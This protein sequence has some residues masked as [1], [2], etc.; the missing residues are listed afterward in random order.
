MK[1]LKALGYYALFILYY[2]ICFSIITLTFYNPNGDSSIGGISVFLMLMA[3]LSPLL[4]VKFL[5]NKF[6]YGKNKKSHAT[7]WV[8]F[9]I[10]ISILHGYGA[11][12]KGVA[13]PSDLAIYSLNAFIVIALL[14]YKSPQTS[15][16]EAA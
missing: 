13:P 2:L 5:I 1:F 15:I 3:I 9:V 16:S 11:D 6:Y 7:S 10:I 12:Y 14:I 8:F 4:M